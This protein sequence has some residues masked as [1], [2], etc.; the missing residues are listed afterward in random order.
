MKMFVL[1]KIIS[2][3]DSQKHHKEV[4]IRPIYKSKQNEL[5][6]TGMLYPYHFLNF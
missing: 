2:R 6:I 3:K 1:L 4:I 5:V